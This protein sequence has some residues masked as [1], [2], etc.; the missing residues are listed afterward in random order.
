MK[1]EMTYFTVQQKKLNKI[2]K[3]LKMPLRIVISLIRYLYRTKINYSLLLPTLK[4]ISNTTEAPTT[5]RTFQLSCS[6]LKWV[7]NVVFAAQF[8][9]NDQTNLRIS[10]TT[11]KTT[12]NYSKKL[13]FIKRSRSNKKLFN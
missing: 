12:T 1:Y 13:L 7:S 3:I 6:S 9:I 10:T 8:L 2:S 5:P 11:L 4:T